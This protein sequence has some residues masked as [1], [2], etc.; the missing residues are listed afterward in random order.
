MGAGEAR[1]GQEE[2][3]RARLLRV[4]RSAAVSARL[5]RSARACIRRNVPLVA[6]IFCGCRWIS[7]AVPTRT[8]EN[9][10]NFGWALRKRILFSPGVM[11]TGDATGNVLPTSEQMQ[12]VRIRE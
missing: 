8:S 12:T 4:L 2:E 10:L 6:S 3:G 11:P 5:P 7:K 9:I 1:G